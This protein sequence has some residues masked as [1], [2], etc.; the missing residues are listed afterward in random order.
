MPILQYYFDFRRCPAEVNQ[1]EFLA[2]IVALVAMSV[3]GQK[4]T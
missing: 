2:I 3:L 4:Q 1:Y